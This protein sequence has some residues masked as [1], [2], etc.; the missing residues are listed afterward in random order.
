MWGSPVGQLGPVQIL[1]VGIDARG[2]DE[3]LSAE[4][5]DLGNQVAIRVLDLLR[6]RKGP[7]GE[8]RRTSGSDP[9]GMPGTLVEALLF[10][11]ADDRSSARR[12]SPPGAPAPED[13]WFLSDLLPRGSAVAIL[14]VEH[15]WA[16]PLRSAIAEIEAGVFG[17]A[18][19]HPRDL[20]AARRT[21]RPMGR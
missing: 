16:I 9:S 2:A 4:V 3:M 6:V 20:A 17:D 11:G 8:L 19:V 15:R 7:G 10:S 1:V 18:W 14:L 5:Q 12:L 13:G 21:A